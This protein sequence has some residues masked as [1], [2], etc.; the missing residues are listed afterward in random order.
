MKDSTQ[1]RCQ[2]KSRESTTSCDSLL[3]VTRSLDLNHAGSAVTTTRLLCLFLHCDLT[4]Y[5]DLFNSL[6]FFILIILIV[7][8]NIT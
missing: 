4:H 6:G 1:V 3:V 7:C 2:D 8:V 5:R